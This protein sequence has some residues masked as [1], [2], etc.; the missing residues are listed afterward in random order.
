MIKRINIASF[1][2][3]REFVWASAVRDTRRK[4][5]VDFK[6]LNIIYGRNY[7]GKTTLSRIIR[8]LET[9]SLPEKYKGCA[10]TLETSLGHLTETML[11]APNYDVRVYNRDFVSDHLSFLT[12]TSKDGVITSFALLGKEN[13][14]ARTEI[15]Q[16]EQELGS[17]DGE[18]GLGFKHY[19]KNREFVT[20]LKQA[21][22]AESRLE[23]LLKEKA[24][25]RETG[26]KYNS[27]YGEPNYNKTRIQVDIDEVI[28]RNLVPLSAKDREAKQILLREVAL[29]HVGR[30]LSFNPKLASLYNQASDL[31]S[32][33][34][35]PTVAI[36][37]LLDDAVLQAWV[38]QGI[39]LHRGK[40]DTCGFCGQPLPPDLWKRLDDHFSEASADLEEALK[41][42]V[43]A[44]Q[45][46]CE[47]GRAIQT[48]KREDLY[49]TYQEDFELARIALTEEVVKYA[50]MLDLIRE[51]LETRLKN[52]F[53]PSSVPRLVDN[54]SEIGAK[55]AAINSLIDQSNNKTKTLARDQVS[56]KRQL[57]ISEVSEFVRN[58]NYADEKKKVDDA[59]EEANRLKSEVDT[60]TVQ[61]QSREKEIE[62]LSAQLRDER[63]GADKVN[64]YLNHYFGLRGLRLEAIEEP[65]SSSFFFRVMRGAEPAFNLSEGECS[66]VAFCYFM[67]KLQETES[68][69]KKRIIYIDDPVSSLDSNHIFFV[70]SLIQN[71][72]ANQRNPEGDQGC[73]E[74]LFISTHNLEFLKYLKR[75]AKPGNNHEQFLI[76]DT[77][78]GSKVE[79]MPYYLRKY[80]TEFNH[81]FHEVYIC[82]DPANI[83][84]HYQS[85]YNFGNNLRRFLEA[86]LFFKY[87]SSEQR[88]NDRVRRFFGDDP[89]TDLI[90]RLINEF[91][92]L[93]E[94]FDRAT[95]PFEIAEISSVAGYVLKKMKENDSE[96]F[97]CLVRSVGGA[98][99]E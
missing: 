75:L 96:Q 26:I 90:S 27:M 13:K 10:F 33:K 78:Q 11:A 77:G 55:I 48:V 70:F 97:E 79:L 51:S 61:I 15:T 2:S 64:E 69:E 52:I 21:S 57:L 74:Q 76:V 32:K 44:V 24:T 9:G 50:G 59:N 83:T 53:V 35:A 72:L 36:Q 3:F 37:E 47:A 67:A 38:K 41:V 30:K 40:R 81:L 82:R 80:V 14:A 6:R 95:Q 63:R 62:A 88:L 93:A 31:V 5:I 99:L 28:R 66:L 23:G 86:F 54:S 91:S 85:F 87:P 71:I 68:S 1:G 19:Q 18:L 60:L 25:G 4:V 73:Y 43:K 12:D 89:S 56:A 94:S 8:S 58:V 98:D 45:E 49:S 7:S 39:P 22:Q 20:K 92:H 46:E 42:Q 17:V 29:P 16:K 65:S 34:I 84:N